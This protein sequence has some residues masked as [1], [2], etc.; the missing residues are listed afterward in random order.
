MLDVICSKEAYI[1]IN[2]QKKATDLI[3]SMYLKI[4]CNDCNDFQYCLSK[5]KK[6]EKRIT[7]KS[8]YIK[9]LLYNCKLEINSTYINILNC[10]KPIS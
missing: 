3:K 5:F 6:V 2:R 10:N 1:Y 8:Q 4:D 7:K 9:T